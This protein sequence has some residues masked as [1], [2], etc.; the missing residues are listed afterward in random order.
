MALTTFGN[1]TK[2]QLCLKLILRLDAFSRSGEAIVFIF[3]LHFFPQGT[4]KFAKI[5]SRVAQSLALAIVGF[6]K[7]GIRGPGEPEAAVTLSRISILW[8]HGISILSNINC[9]DEF[10]WYRLIPRHPARLHC[11]YEERNCLDY[12][13]RSFLLPFFFSLSR[14]RPFRATVHSYFTFC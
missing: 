8:F 13:P 4:F 9:S 11:S 7:I 2:C 14:E 1:C 6:H 10:L 12:D 5:P 3:I